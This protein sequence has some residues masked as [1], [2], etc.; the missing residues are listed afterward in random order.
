M[1]LSLACHCHSSGPSWVGKRACKASATE[2]LVCCRLCYALGKA[3]SKNSAEV[4]QQQSS[5]SEG[6]T[7]TPC[8]MNQCP[9]SCPGGSWTGRTQAS[10]CSPGPAAA[11]PLQR[12]RLARSRLSVHISAHPLRLAALR[13]RIGRLLAPGSAHSCQGESLPSQQP[14]FKDRERC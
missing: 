6:R 13:L 4:H 9:A 10:G 12:R 3:N 5:A 14:A 1:F 8:R 7:F 11:A 2:E